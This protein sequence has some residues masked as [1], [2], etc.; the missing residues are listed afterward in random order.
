MSEKKAPQTTPKN[1][2]PKPTPRPTPPKPSVDI[3]IKSG[4]PPQKSNDK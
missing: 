3:A 4:T 2:P 1:S